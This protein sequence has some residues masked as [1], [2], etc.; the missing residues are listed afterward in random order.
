MILRKNPYRELESAIGYRFRKRKWLEQAITHPSYAHEQGPDT[1]DNQRLE[2]LGDAALGLVSADVLY[3]TNPA[4]AEGE[5]TKMRSL[6]S[7]TKALAETAR[8]VNLGA[9]LKLGRGEDVGGGRIRPTI[10]ADALEAVIGA[11]YRDGGLRAV[12]R[13]FARLFEARLLESQRSP[14]HENPKGELQEWAQRKGCGTPRY[15][16]VGEEG[17]PH[18]RVFTVEVR[19]ADQPMGT[20]RGATKREAETNAAAHA[21]EQLSSRSNENISI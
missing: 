15:A 17:P 4:A 5:L 1:P 12:Q 10:L 21:L 7:S 19:V 8:A 16:A 9:Y 6:V 11:A 14:W 18:Q 2:F 20:G 13:I 3:E